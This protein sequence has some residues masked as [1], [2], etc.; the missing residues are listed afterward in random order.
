MNT[1]L[2]LVRHATCALTDSVLLGRTLDAPLDD[3]GRR[4]AAAVA[5]R[6]SSERPALIESSPRRRTRETAEAIAAVTGVDVQTSPELDEVDFGAWGGRRFDDLQ[7]DPAWREWNTNRAAAF[8]PAGDGIAAVQLRITNHLRRVARA[9]PRATVI[10]VSHA[11]PIRAALLAYLGWPPD[12]WHRLSIEPASV[13]TL[14][15][16]PA[17][18]R[19][20]P[21]IERI[22]ETAYA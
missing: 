17:A 9:F 16:D 15:V 10:I 11:E 2:L 3:R 5:E 12:D 14:L 22:G 19:A 1:R 6:L 13:T 20:A 21:R 4:Q 7:R 8:T 18:P